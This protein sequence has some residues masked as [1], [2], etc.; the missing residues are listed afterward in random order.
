MGSAAVPADFRFA[1]YDGNLW[2][3]QT[4]NLTY[5]EAKTL[6]GFE[7]E[8]VTV[9]PTH[10]VQEWFFP[11]EK[12]GG[13]IPVGTDIGG[14]QL[15]F[16][17]GYNDK[18]G[19]NTTADQLRWPEAGDPWKD[20]SVANYWGD[21]LVPQDIGAVESVVS[22]RPRASY[23]TTSHHAS[24]A[25]GAHRFTLTGQRMAPKALDNRTANGILIERHNG[26]ARVHAL[27][28]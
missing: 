13:G 17:G 3:W 18:D 28:R 20:K 23:R 12:F 14:M 4:A 7:V 15:A 24:A 11:W 27:P 19:D 9:D 22:V 5:A 21:I 10:K 8:A 6:Y 26:H 25:P 1:C 2:T 16:A